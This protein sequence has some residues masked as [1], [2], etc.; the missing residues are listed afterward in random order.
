MGLGARPVYLAGNP[1]LGY[2]VFVLFSTIVLIVLFR[3]GIL[4]LGATYFATNLLVTFPIT[5]RLSSWYAMHMLIGLAAFA[6]VVGWSF[7]ISLAGRCR[8]R[9]ARTEG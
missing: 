6:A 3:V 8:P 9:R 1:W 4:A 5:F 2:T 7:Y